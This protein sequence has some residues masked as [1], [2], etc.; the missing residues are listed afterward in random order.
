ME[1]KYEYQDLEERESIISANSNLVLIEEQ[2]ITT[3]NFLI[4]VDANTSQEMLK[5]Q[6]LNSRVYAISGYLTQDATNLAGVE[7]AILKIEKNK[8]ING[9]M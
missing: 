2:N 3:G 8:I 9:G 1:Y 5:T 6:E 7:D 4:F